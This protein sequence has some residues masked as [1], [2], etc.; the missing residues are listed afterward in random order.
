VT[1]EVLTITKWEEGHPPDRVKERGM[2]IAHMAKNA[3]PKA[4]YREI[5]AKLGLPRWCGLA[6]AR[7]QMIPVVDED[8]LRQE[9]PVERPQIDVLEGGAD[10]ASSFAR[11][12]GALT[13]AKSRS[14]P[15]PLM[16][17]KVW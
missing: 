5:A 14:K 8:P 2:M 13:G 17:V 12:R 16:L 3:L 6:S 4:K 10:A 9:Q 1:P 7:P 11:A 15:M